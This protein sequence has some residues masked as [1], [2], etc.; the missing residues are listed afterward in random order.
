MKEY[1]PEFAYEDIIH[2]EHPVSSRHTPMPAINRAAQFAPFAALTGYN[3]AIEETAR[4]VDTR[5]V[6]T[7]SEMAV[8]DEKLREID[9]YTSDERTE[10]VITWFRPDEQKEGGTYIR[11]KGIVRKID[12]QKRRLLMDGGEVIPMDEVISIE[13]T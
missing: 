1:N 3:E 11:T 6:L 10:V 12:R 5:I 8:L 4:Q 7:E 2:M 9:K 13:N